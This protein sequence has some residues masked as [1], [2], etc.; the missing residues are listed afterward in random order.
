MKKLFYGMLLASITIAT[1]SFS[2]DDFFDDLMATDEMK[3]VE[4][5]KSTFEKGKADAYKLLSE[6]PKTLK[7]EKKQNKIKIKEETVKSAIP[8]VYNPAPMG[9][10][11][12]AP[13]AEIEYLRVHLTQIKV[14]DYPNTYKATNFPKPIS[15]FRETLLSFGQKD[16]LWR[17]LSYGNFIEDDSS[18]SKGLTMYRKYYAMLDKKYGNAEDFYTPSTMNIEE[19]VPN[20]DGTTSMAIKQIEMEIGDDGFLEKLASGEAVLYST[21]HNDEVSVTLALLADGNNQSFIVIEYKN[22]TLQKKAD[23]EIFDAL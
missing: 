23:E 14:K 2:A 21:F 10:L 19:P 9:L 5:K 15:D 7:I 16:S 13:I 6:K 20:D 22:L 17:I 12:L 18:A 11:W 3:Q 1:P 4:N 8:V